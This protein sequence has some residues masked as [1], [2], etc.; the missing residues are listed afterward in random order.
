[1]WGLLLRAVISAAVIV[2]VSEVAHRSQRIGALLLSL[3]LMSILALVMTW[4]RHHDLETISRLARETL[5]LVLLGLP[6]FVP[7]ALAARWGWGFWTALLAGL[8][9]AAVTT[10]LWLWLGP[11]TF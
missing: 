11:K 4:T 5:I 1:M 8:G 10:T 3:P 7:L 9:M 2:A 6:C